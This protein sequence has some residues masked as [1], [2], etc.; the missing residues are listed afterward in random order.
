MDLNMK[1]SLA[2]D[3]M[4]SEGPGY[5]EMDESGGATGM[6]DHLPTNDK[7]V[8]ADFYNDFDDLFDEDNW[9]R[10]KAAGDGVK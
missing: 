7:H 5:M 1:P 9:A 4:F 2:A 10:T 6:M 8:H 3:E